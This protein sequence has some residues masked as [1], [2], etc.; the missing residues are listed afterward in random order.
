MPKRS[1]SLRLRTS[2]LHHHRL[3]QG[4]TRTRPDKSG[5]RQLVLPL[6]G[7]P[8]DETAVC[9]RPK[10]HDFKVYGMMRKMISGFINGL[11]YRFVVAA[12]KRSKKFSAVCSPDLSGQVLRIFRRELL[13]QQKGYSQP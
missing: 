5:L 13:L 1:K 9:P 2:G 3:P 4:S 10:V 6:L 8:G 7:S 11:E 12:N